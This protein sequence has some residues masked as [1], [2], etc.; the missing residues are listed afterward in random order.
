MLNYTYGTNG[1]PVPN[2]K[3]YMVNLWPTDI[4]NINNL[5]IDKKSRNI[6]M[7]HQFVTAIGIE[8]E[9]SDSEFI[10]LGGIDNV[11]VLFQ[12]FL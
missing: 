1:M 6:I 9:R 10:S 2:G 5:D 7:V 12:D 3:D 4:D 8:I 11:D